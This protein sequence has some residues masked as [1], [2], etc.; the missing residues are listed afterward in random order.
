MTTGLTWTQYITQIATLAVVEETNAAFVEIQPQMVTYA[1]NRICRDIDFLNTVL[2]STDYVTASGIPTVVIPP[3]DFVT[4]QQVNVI[5]PAG[6][7][8][9]TAGTLVPL[10]P[11]TKEFL[12][13]VYPSAAS[14]AEPMYFA[15]LDQSTIKMG[16]W[17]D[18]VYT[19]QTVGTFRPDS[20]SASNP[21]TFIS[22]YLPDLLIMASM[23][24]V[25]MF[26]R[27]F[28][29]VSSGGSPDE[30]EMAG[31]YEGQY[32]ALLAGA[33]VEEARKKFQASGWT[34]MSPPVAATPAR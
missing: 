31:S 17:P 29:K 26:Q 9:P 30:P 18:G 3:E 21:T 20:L 2:S 25:T 16:P 19:L 12:D 10:L 15:M 24:Y 5:T 23:I 32:K 14:K 34:S 27:N 11:A 8:D 33:M 4:L 7:T 22:L 1:T 6:T 28:G 13:Y